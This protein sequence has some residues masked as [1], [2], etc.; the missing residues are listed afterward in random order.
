MNGSKRV[1]P[2]GADIKQEKIMESGLDLTISK[3]V[4]TPNNMKSVFK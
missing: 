2:D 4:N 1:S 3:F